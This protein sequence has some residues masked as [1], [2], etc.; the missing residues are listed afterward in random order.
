MFK[1][2]KV[3]FEINMG[4]SPTQQLDFEEEISPVPHTKSHLFVD[5]VR[6]G[7]VLM[8]NQALCSALFTDP[9]REQAYPW[10][11]QGQAACLSHSEGREKPPDGLPGGLGRL[12]SFVRN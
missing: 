1:K 4:T 6:F 8:N 5:R 3:I 9:S 2:G 10:V 7:D 12:G 11:F